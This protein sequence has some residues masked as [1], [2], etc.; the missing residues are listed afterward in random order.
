MA[1]SSFADKARAPT[2]AD[3]RV[4]LGQAYALWTKL[5]ALAANRFPTIT[6]VWKFSGKMTG[7]GLRLVDRERVILYMTPQDGQFL[8]SFV[9]GERAT[10][11]TRRAKLPA[12]VQQAIEAATRYAEGRGIRIPVQRAT[13]LAAL[14]RLAEIKYEN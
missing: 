12:D 4:A 8:V 14:I 1:L 3:L 9:L 11:A 13:K 2:E 5:L 6:P 10:A 7:W